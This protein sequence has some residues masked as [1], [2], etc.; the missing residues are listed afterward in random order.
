MHRHVL[1]PS[2]SS[3]IETKLNNVN[4]HISFPG[5]IWQTTLVAVIRSLGSRS[6]WLIFGIFP[7]SFTFV[8]LD[9]FPL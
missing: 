2:T 7:T 6:L 4:F 3:F 9:T 8:K 5:N 1:F